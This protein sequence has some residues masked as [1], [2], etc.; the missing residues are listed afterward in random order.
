MAVT[1]S[2][3]LPFSPFVRRPPSR[4]LVPRYRHEL[5]DRVVREIDSLL[6]HRRPARLLRLILARQTV[7]VI[8]DIRI[9]EIELATLR[10][11]Q[12]QPPIGRV[13]RGRGQCHSWLSPFPF[14]NSKFAKVQLKQLPMQLGRPFPVGNKPSDSLIR[15]F[16]FDEEASGQFPRVA[17][18]LN[19]D[20]L[21][22][23]T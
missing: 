17:S 12:G 2:P 6:G 3:F 16:T 20:L 10:R 11:R 4:V 22:T 23:S 15:K 18:M 13:E 1:F 14:P 5:V 8:V 21:I 19:N 9:L 7:E